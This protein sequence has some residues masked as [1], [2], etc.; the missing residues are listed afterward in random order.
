MVKISRNREPFPLITIIQWRPAPHKA[1]NISAP[2]P[3]FQ[4]ESMSRFFGR[5][6]VR[7][8]RGKTN[9]CP[10]T[11][12]SL[13]RKI[14]FLTR[15]IESLT[16]KIESLTRKIAFLTC[17]IESLT[18][19]IESLTDADSKNTSPNQ[20]FSYLGKFAPKI[21]KHPFNSS[22]ANN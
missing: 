8:I 9:S 10:F 2:L 22:K 12:C 3:F 19:K 20:H 17:K 5:L 11:N 21:K 18:R 16:R 4:A 13:T 6:G 1:L 15:K 7:S 14:V